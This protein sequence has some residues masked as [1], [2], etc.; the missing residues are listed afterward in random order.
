MEQNI[1]KINVRE[2]L[3]KISNS[4]IAQNA[5][6]T[7]NKLDELN[8]ELKE[9]LG[10]IKFISQEMGKTNST[11]SFKNI[12]DK[13][14]QIEDL[15]NK[16]LSERYIKV[17]SGLYLEKGVGDSWD[18]LGRIFKIFIFV[19]EEFDKIIKSTNTYEE[20][21]NQINLQISE[22]LNIL[23]V[24]HQFI[25]ELSGTLN[26]NI[27]ILKSSIHDIYNINDIT[28]VPETTII[29]KSKFKVDVTFKTKFGEVVV[30]YD[31]VVQDATYGVFSK[32]FSNLELDKINDDYFKNLNNIYEQIKPLFNKKYDGTQT[33]HGGD[34][35][36]MKNLYAFNIE[37][38]Q[39]QKTMNDVINKL[40]EYEHYMFRFSNYIS[41]QVYCSTVLV[42]DKQKFDYVYIDK[43]ILEEYNKKIS[44]IIQQFNNFNQ[45]TNVKEKD[46]I[47]YFNQ[48]HYFTIKKL[49]KFIKFLL[50]NINNKIIDIKKCKNNVYQLFIIF[51]QFK[52]ILDVY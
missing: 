23:K 37:L 51:N 39:T 25:L 1:N 50:E 40:K 33:Q 47:I 49:S 6:S 36:M 11:L 22:T 16:I 52:D 4:N 15:I 10:M 20:V 44:K 17:S 42:S 41:Y 8:N 3:E 34:N 46:A 26:K 43:L 29:D 7:Q 5:Q 48:Y 38:Q 32:L 24:F 27:H 9:T 19:K 31:G 21:S 14:S 2:V 35:D 45:I 30:G 12:K 13:V 28:Y 18:I